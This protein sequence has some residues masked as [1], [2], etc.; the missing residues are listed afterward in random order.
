MTKLT[1]AIEGLYAAFRD[2]PPARA[3]EGCRHCLDDEEIAILLRTPLRAITEQQLTPYAS[4]VFLTLGSVSDFLYFLPRILE[5]SAT[6]DNWYPLPEIVGRAIANTKP[7]TW[8]TARRSALEQLLHAIIE[9]A[10]ESRDYDKLD[11]WLCAI[12][13]MGL[14]VEPYLN[15]VEASRDAVLGYFCQ[16][17]TELQEG[18]LANA[19]WEL[20]NQAH[21]TI[22]EWFNTDKV[23]AIPAEEYG[24]VPRRTE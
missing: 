21:E 17:A 8:S 12:G 20:P 5:V 4:S 24:Y 22:V 18:R 11:S 15:L 2:Q 13:R 19:F 3:I 7:D 16:N 1:Q 23:R 14:P 10:I 9:G 6:D